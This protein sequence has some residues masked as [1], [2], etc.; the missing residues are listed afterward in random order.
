MTNSTNTVMKN[1][2]DAAM[3]AQACG[4]N[5]HV[6]CCA[7]CQRAQLARWTIQLAEATARPRAALNIGGRDA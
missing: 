1:A 3:S 5:R 6:G 7:C 4:H 2:S